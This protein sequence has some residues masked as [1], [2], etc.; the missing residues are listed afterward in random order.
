MNAPR[1]F[2]PDLRCFVSGNDIAVVRRL[3]ELVRSRGLE[4]ASAAELRAGQT[5]TNEVVRL[6]SDADFV[7]VAISEGP[8]AAPAFELGLAQGM[9]KPAF[10]V[11]VGKPTLDLNTAYI[12]AIEDATKVDDVAEDFDRF[13]RHAGRSDR[14]R[15]S[16]E[17]GRLD[18]LDWAREELQALRAS[19]SGD[20]F[21]RF[22]TICAKIFRAAGAEVAEVGDDRTVGADLVVWLNDI[23]FELG[24]PTLVECK[25]YGGGVGSVIK[26]SE[27]TVRKIEAVMNRSDAKLALLVYDHD[28]ATVPP[29]LFETPRVLSFAI[30]DLIHAV[31]HLELEKVILKRRERALFAGH[32][33]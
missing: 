28:R 31:E 18:S 27:A 14:R 5:I 19:E 7:V 17:P 23:A 9:G 22:E 29:S 16:V 3:V 30:E 4:A 2:Q 1:D 24:G 12:V 25:F 10:V 11:F 26:N 6:I 33:Q 15:G 21:K 20:R 13:V 8:Q 32:N